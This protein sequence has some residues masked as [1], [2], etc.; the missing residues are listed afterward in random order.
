MLPFKN[1]KG[2]KSMMSDSGYKCSLQRNWTFLALGRSCDSKPPISTDQRR[3][4][5]MDV[6]NSASGKEPTWQYKRHG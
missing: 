2:Q 3:H 6:Q 5:F 1:F 4:S